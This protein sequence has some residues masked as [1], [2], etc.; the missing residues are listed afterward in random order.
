MVRQPKLEKHLKICSKI[1]RIT[2]KFQN[3][4][5]PTFEENFKLLGDLPFTVYFDLETTC[6]KKLCQDFTDPLKYMYP[7][8]YCFIIAFNPAFY[9]NKITVLRSFTNTIEELAGVSYFTD[10]MLRHRD[11]ITTLQLL[12][13]LQN[14]ASKKSEYSLIEMFCCELK[15]AVDICKKWVYEKCMRKNLSLELT[16]KTEFKKENLLCYDNPCVICGF[17]LG[18][19]KV[20]GA[21]SIKLSYYDFTVKKEHKFL[22]NIFSEDELKSSPCISNLN[23][24]YEFFEKFY[25]DF[26]Q[27]CY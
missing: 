10:D 20:Y 15:F 9:L 5:L 16:T 18:T 2:Y 21:N 6:G 25:V 22:R 1:P 24:R 26:S 13:Y 23:T 12:G 17:E 3:E 8:S 27:A 7:V 14:V 19:A 4:H 11:P